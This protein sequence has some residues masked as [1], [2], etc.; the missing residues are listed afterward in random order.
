V[1]SIGMKDNLFQLLSKKP[2][3]KAEKCRQK[4]ENSLPPLGKLRTKLKK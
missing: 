3:L 1:L 2:R 4:I